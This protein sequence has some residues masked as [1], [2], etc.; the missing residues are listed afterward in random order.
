[1]KEISMEEQSRS[2]DEEMKANNI[3]EE[4]LAKSNEP[5]FVSALQ[6]K[7]NAQKDAKEKPL[8]FR[9][10]EAQELKAAQASSNADA[11]RGLVSMFTTRGKNF[12]SV[13]KQ[14]QTTKSKDEEERAAVVAKI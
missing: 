14:Q 5:S 7:K 3:T 13:V 6:E 11:S 12:D 10:N 2:V 1:D 9:K 8:Q 4:Q